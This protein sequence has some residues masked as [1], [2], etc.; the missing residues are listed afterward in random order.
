M[1]YLEKNVLVEPLDR[2]IVHWARNRRLPCYY[3]NEDGLSKRC[4]KIQFG[5]VTAYFVAGRLVRLWA[6]ADRVLLDEM[7]EQLTQLFS[8]CTQRNSRLLDTG[9]AAIN[10]GRNIWPNSP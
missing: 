9:S 6:H 8:L 3:A 2:E 7:F 4:L 10:E 1:D 5:H